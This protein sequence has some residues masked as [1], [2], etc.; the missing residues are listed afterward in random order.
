VTPE[1][2]Q[3]WR[4]L[5]SMTLI[6][7][8]RRGTLGPGPSMVM[9]LSGMGWKRAAVRVLSQVLLVAPALFPWQLTSAT[10]AAATCY[11]PGNWQVGYTTAADERNRGARARI[12]F[13]N[14]DLCGSDT[15]GPSASVA[16]SMVTAPATHASGSMWAQAG[17]GQFAFNG[18]DIATFTQYTKKCKASASCTGSPVETRFDT[19]NPH[20]P[21]TY[22]AFVDSD[23][24]IRME[25]GGSGAYDTTT[26]DPSGDWESQ[27]RL[28]YF[29]ETLHRPTD[30]VG[31]P[32]D[33]TLF[34]EIKR[35]GQGRE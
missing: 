29:G 2:K 9:N 17:Y 5:L 4:S 1:S 35:M 18:R 13:E 28:Q 22:R 16:W 20:D 7:V 25:A 8:N 19:V 3:F 10:A 14:P 12:Q 24:H 31:L 26:Y 15:D 34:D 27:W 21:M 6:G 11:D 23:G 32:N 30:V 33:R